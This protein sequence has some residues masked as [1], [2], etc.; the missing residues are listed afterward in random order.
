MCPC[1]WHAAQRRWS[2]T[3]TCMA[4]CRW[5]THDD[6]LGL[7]CF[8]N[9]LKVDGIELHACMHRASSMKRRANKSQAMQPLHAPLSWNEERRT[10]ETPASRR[11][12]TRL[13]APGHSSPEEVRL[14]TAHTAARRRS[15]PSVSSRLGRCAASPASSMPSLPSSSPEGRARRVCERLGVLK[16]LGAC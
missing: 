2:T 15:S 16:L 4:D 14:M 10:A 11:M 12:A 13:A 7:V 9:L 6:F 8:L 3:C 5:Y 1:R